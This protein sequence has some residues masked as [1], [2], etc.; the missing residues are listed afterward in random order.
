M[1]PGKS[2]W[3][4]TDNKIYNLITPLPG[5]ATIFLNEIMLFA[6]GPLK[7]WLERLLNKLN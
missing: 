4:E 2:T 3:V 6:V 1:V 7:I 5:L